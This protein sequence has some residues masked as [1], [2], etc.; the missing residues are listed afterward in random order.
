MMK[1]WG[2]PVV[3][4][5]LICAVPSW[6]EFYRYR[7]ANGVLRFTDNIAEVPENQRPKVKQYGEA[8]D[9]MTP[10]EKAKTAEAEAAKAAAQREKLKEA[11]SPTDHGIPADVTDPQFVSY[12]N[13]TKVALDNEY[14]VLMKEKSDIE[15]TKS[16]LKTQRDIQRYEK[17]VIDLN[18]RI[19]DFNRRRDEFKAKADAFNQGAK[20]Q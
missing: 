8:T 17:R 18:D 5:C 1:R 15:A 9:G 20:P 3:A 2:V 16:T 7:D 14:A 13:R 4:I 11:L 12:L 19:K 6:G 10:E